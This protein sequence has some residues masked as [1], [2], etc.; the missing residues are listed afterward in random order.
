MI[1]HSG[2]SL[3]GHEFST[4][5]TEQPPA[6]RFAFLSALRP[7]SD[8]EPIS[9]HTTPA[10]D[11]ADSLPA[12]PVS[13]E[14]AHN[15]RSA[16][17]ARRRT[18]SDIGHTVRFREPDSD[19]VVHSNAPSED[20][21]SLVGSEVSDQTDASIRLKKRKRGPR[22][23]AKYALAFPA[24]QLRTKQRAF[25]HIRPR[26]LLQLQELGEKRAIP[27]FDVVP[28]SL[29]AGTLIIPALAKLYPRMFY[30]KPHLGQNDLLLVRS[31]DYGVPHSHHHHPHL[32]H[33]HDNTDNNSNSK[34]LDHQDVLAVVS[35]TSDDD[36]VEIVFQDGSTWTSSRMANGSYEFNHVNEQGENVKARWVKRSLMS[37]R[38]SWGSANTANTAPS[39]PT[40]PTAPDSRWTF[41]IID[42]STRRHPIQGILNST[43]LEVFDTYN[44]MST[45][46][47]IYPPTRG[48]GSDMSGISEE[49]TTSITDE[50][51]TLEVTEYTKT[52]MLATATWVSLRQRG[53]PASAT[54]KIP[55]VVSQR[56]SSGR[57]L[58]PSIDIP[59]GIDSQVSSATEGMPSQDISATGQTPTTGRIQR[60]VSSGS[61]FMRRRRE[62]VAASAATTFAER[63]AVEKLGDLEVSEEETPTCR[64]RIRRFTHKLFHHSRSQ[65]V[66]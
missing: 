56:V 55:R 43:S 62:A 3:H 40:T 6:R 36:T 60:A 38:A 16:L 49:D 24:P 18:T 19:V 22:K 61:E 26:V 63:E 30:A 51:T 39:S 41:S 31:E 32:H 42:P 14:P 53:W 11:A 34:N 13:V 47:G 46:S 58:S 29:I 10:P 44:T 7:L 50:R 54:P 15:P 1:V 64:V 35:T 27:A 4:P 9:R 66:S 28:S 25:F 21:E 17:A 48:F 8:V 57:C 37:P 45:S 20:E 33:H 23:S 65:R 12:R 52:L 2:A 59:R 5:P